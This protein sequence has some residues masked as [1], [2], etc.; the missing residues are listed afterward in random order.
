MV[1]TK[2]QLK[3]NTSPPHLT[4]KAEIKQLMVIHMTFGRNW[5][6]EQDI[7]DQ[8][9]DHEDVPRHVMMAIYSDVTSLVTPGLKTA[10]GLHRTYVAMR[11]DIKVPHT[12]FASRTK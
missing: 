6:I 7:P 2:R 11:P 1:G 8:S 5:T 9:M 10:D 12:L 4:V 3:L